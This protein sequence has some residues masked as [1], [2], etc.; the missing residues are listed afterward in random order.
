MRGGGLVTNK[1]N[2]VKKQSPTGDFLGPANHVH[3]FLVGQLSE[4][5]HHGGLGEGHA[6][7]AH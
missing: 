3:Q 2:E 7:T 1:Q 5:H 4:G 6:G